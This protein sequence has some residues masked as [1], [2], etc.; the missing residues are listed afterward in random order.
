MGKI[1]DAALTAGGSAIGVIPAALRD[2]EI[3]HTGL[4]ELHV[5]DSMHSRKLRMAELADAFIAMPG[6]F[7]T[8][9]ESFEALT[10]TQLGIHSKPLGFL[11]VDG[12]YDGLL[13]FADTQTAHGFVRAAHRDM[14]I[15]DDG[16]EA[17]IDQ[18]ANVELP[19]L[20]KW[21]NDSLKA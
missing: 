7:G 11:N 17:L 2:K 20:G 13:S 10:W 4:T 14:V 18:L 9:D 12:F 8:L 3:A 5:V 21:R 6:G 19:S 1:A 16:P 15:A